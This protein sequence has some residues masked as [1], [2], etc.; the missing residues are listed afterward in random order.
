MV[1]TSEAYRIVHQFVIT[2]RTLRSF[3][4]SV[5]NNNCLNNFL[6]KCIFIKCTD[7]RFWRKFTKIYEV[8]RVV[9]FG[10]NPLDAHRSH[11]KMN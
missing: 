1:R 9:Q 3:L 2:L 4:S 7:I 11:T 10:K 6:Y 5:K 8:F